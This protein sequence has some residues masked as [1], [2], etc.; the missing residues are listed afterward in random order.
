MVAL[1][2]IAA[3]TALPPLDDDRVPVY[4]G[5]CLLLLVLPYPC[6]IKLPYKA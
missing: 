3:S 1:D 2:T 4:P 5:L 6:T